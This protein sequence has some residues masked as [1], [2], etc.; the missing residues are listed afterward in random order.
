[1]KLIGSY[2]NTKSG[3]IDTKNNMYILINRN[4]P[5]KKQNEK[6]ILLDNNIIIYFR[7]F[8]WTKL[9]HIFHNE[10]PWTFFELLC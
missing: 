4:Q 1:M 9:R 3:N 2:Y 7:L 10:Y 6:N 8:I 5:N